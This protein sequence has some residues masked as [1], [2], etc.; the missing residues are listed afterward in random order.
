MN[1]MTLLARLASDDPDATIAIDA[2]R[3]RPLLV[4]RHALWR[5]ALSVRAALARRGV[6]PGDCV[7]VWLPNWSDAL[8]WQFGTAA[9]GAHVVGINTRYNTDEVAHVMRRARPAIV[10]VA[11]DFNGLDLIGTL[12]QAIAAAPGAAPSVAVV[13]GPHGVSPRDT[14]GYDVGGGAWLLDAR[15]GREIESGERPDEGERLAVAFTTSGSTGAPKLAAHTGAAVV[16]HGLADAAAIGIQPGDVVLCALPL[17]GVF[18]F[19]TAMAAIAGGAAC[20]LEPVFDEDAVIADMARWAVT[21]V[22]GADDMVLRLAQAWDRNQRELSRWR[23]L[24]IADFLGRSHTLAAWAADRFG[25]HT[26]GVYGSSEV[27]A[28]AAL[29]PHDEP[30]PRRWSAGGRPVSPEIKARVVDP[31]TGREV[32]PGVEGELQV[33]GPNV[34]D[35]YLGDRAAAARSFTADGWLRTGDLATI[36]DDG[37]ITYVCRMG[38]ALRLRGFLVDPA[39]IEHRLAEHDVVAVAKV[40]GIAGPDGADR[41][42]AFVQLTEPGSV[43]SD[44]LRDWCA[45][46][47]APFKVP[48]AVHVVAEMPTTSGTNGTKIRASTL[49]TWAEQLQASEHDGEHRG[50]R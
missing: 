47:I 33:R 35:T 23:W 3:R 9:L 2:D 50:T 26:T 46:A 29:W 11:H 45:R 1:P 43:S 10:A 24:G 6:S 8:A 16:A 41:A 4:S 12:R 14:S 30:A 27:F 49:R 20:L 28:L 38:D 36:D 39:E 48:S 17:A 37:G 19:S 21:H 25:T 18:G 31:S 15:D 5:H 22:V 32:N 40:V 42:I 7:A 13:P 34:V 44:T